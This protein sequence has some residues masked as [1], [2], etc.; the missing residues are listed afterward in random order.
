VV[1]KGEEG[2]KEELPLCG[3]SSKEQSADT[4]VE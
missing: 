4:Y 2:M 1:V 3:A